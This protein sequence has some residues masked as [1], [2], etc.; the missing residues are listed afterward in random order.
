MSRIEKVEAKN[1]GKCCCC[2][3]QWRTC[4]KFLMVVRDNGTPIRG[5]RYCVH[6]EK[7]A[8]LNNPDTTPE[9]DAEHRFEREREEFAAYYTQGMGSRYFEDRGY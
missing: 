1:W 7:Y 4:E 3:A 6:C 2:G 9:E 5:E 8:K